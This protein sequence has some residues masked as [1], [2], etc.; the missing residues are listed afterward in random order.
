MHTSKAPIKQGEMAGDMHPYAED[1]L[2]IG[3]GTLG[4]AFEFSERA[5]PG[6]I[7]RFYRLFVKSEVASS[8]SEGNG[9]PDIGVS[10]IELVLGICEETNA[11]DKVL[12][13]LLQ[14]PISLSRNDFAC[15]RWIGQALARYQWDCGLSF[16]SIAM[17][18]DV[19]DLRRIYE[20]CHEF[21]WG[22]VI[23]TIESVRRTRTRVT[24]L[25]QLRVASG[26]TQTALAAASGVSLRSIQQYEQRRK[27]INKAQAFSV[28]RLARVL[29]CQMEEL[30]EVDAA[31][32]GLRV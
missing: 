7:D 32:E 20:E 13:E 10:G 6:G 1:H 29:G 28:Y 11:R 19:A 16:R 14:D 26:L 4:K 30:V 25:G 5:L 18:L 2:A 24:H 17:F 27:D 21:D 3:M 15:A 8:F 22:V 9:G 12:D 23:D 31:R